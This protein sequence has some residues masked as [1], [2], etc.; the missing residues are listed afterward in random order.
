MTKINCAVCG[1]PFH[2]EDE[3]RSCPDCEQEADRDEEFSVCPICSSM[4]EW[5]QCWNCHGEGGFHDCGEDCCPCLHP[6]LDLNEVC[7]ECNGVGG[8]QVC[9]SLPHTDE[10]MAEYRKRTEAAK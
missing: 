9:L 6:E 8:Y 1:K 7:E 4:M 5:E 3:E 10:Q 2:T